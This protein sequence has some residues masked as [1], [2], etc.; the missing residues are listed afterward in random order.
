VGV[1]LCKVK[2]CVCVGFVLCVSFYDAYLY[3]LCCVLFIPCFCVVSFMYVSL[4]V[5]SVLPLSDNSIAV[6]NTNNNNLC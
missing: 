2:V 3:L 4:I 5:L 6:N 1:G